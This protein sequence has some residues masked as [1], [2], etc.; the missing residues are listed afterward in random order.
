ML[1]LRRTVT[2]LFA[3]AA[4]PAEGLRVP[5]VGTKLARPAFTRLAVPAPKLLVATPMPT[6]FKA[7]SEVI[8]LNKFAIFIEMVVRQFTY[9]MAAVGLIKAPT[10]TLDFTF[11]WRSDAAI[12]I[13][14]EEEDLVFFATEEEDEEADDQEGDFEFVWRP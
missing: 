7:L 2:I 5:F 12:V 10:T 13:E 9:L 1:S 8:P 6:P 14:E 3:L 11:A 4:T